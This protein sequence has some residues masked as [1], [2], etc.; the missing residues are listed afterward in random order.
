MTLFSGL[1][2]DVKAYVGTFL[3]PQERKSLRCTHKNA[4]VWAESLLM[5]DFLKMGEGTLIGKVARRATSPIEVIQIVDRI[6]R[7]EM[8]ILPQNNLFK[9][10][11]ESLS[12]KQKNELGKE[13]LK[14]KS[15]VLYSFF[16][17]IVSVFPENFSSYTA[18]NFIK[19]LREIES[20]DQKAKQVRYWIRENLPFL[21]EIRTLELGDVDQLYPPEIVN[22]TELQGRDLGRIFSSQAKL[23]NFETI[24]KLIQ[25]DLFEFISAENLGKAL[26]FAC[27]KGFGEIVKVI[28]D[29]GSF[30]TI[31]LKYIESALS[32]Q[33]CKKIVR[34]MRKDTLVS[35]SFYGLKRIVNVLLS[36]NKISV[37]DLER[38]LIAS[39]S[40]GHLKVVQ[41]II[42]SMRF[43]EINID[44][45]GWAL[46]KAAGNG[47]LSVVQA[48]A[49]TRRFRDL[50]LNTILRAIKDS[51][52]EGHFAV[53]REFFQ[54]KYF[55]M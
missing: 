32:S 31:P 25:S 46:C 19:Q 30:R 12:Y 38:A 23:G 29:S 45:I 27:K 4:P 21:A 51:A 52:L 3:P 6:L 49:E 5:D 50:N 26:K 10:S 35:A 34:T 18:R 20:D 47:H 54:S 15:K 40:K 24:V 2:G 48:I 53:V 22:L 16:E 43:N 44:E 9:D 37:N 14:Q 39:A 41:L 42:R 8:T 17:K 7:K 36:F 28:I 55:L 13:V 33:Y 11:M 1:P